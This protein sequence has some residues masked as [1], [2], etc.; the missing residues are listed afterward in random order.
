[1]PTG[2][3]AIQGDFSR[4]AGAFARLGEPT[5]E[6][7]TAEDLAAVDRLVIPGGESTTVA[8][9]LQRYGLGEAIR[10]RA[11]AGMPVWGTCMGMILLARAIE[12]R[13]EQWTLS[14]LDITVRRNAFGA[15]V[16]SFESE[17][18]FHGLDRPVM[19]VFIRAPIVTEVGP[20]VQVLSSLNGQIVAVQQGQRLG[21]SF[22]PELTEETALHAYFLTLELPR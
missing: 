3:L 8:L 12:A 10:T 13:P 7:R 19:G 14:L 15:Q 22:H 11:E 17:V 1:M 18:P 2:V 16:H 5:C 20:G 6:V 9:L 21:T 4:H